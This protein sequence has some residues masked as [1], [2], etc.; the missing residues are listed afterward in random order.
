MLPYHQKD[1]NYPQ[2]LITPSLRRQHQTCP[3]TAPDLGDWQLLTPRLEV[4]LAFQ[5]PGPS[6]TPVRW[7]PSLMLLL[8]SAS[9]KSGCAKHWHMGSHPSIPSGFS[10]QILAPRSQHIH[11]FLHLLR[12]LSMC[13]WK[14]ILVLQPEC[15]CSSKICV[16][17]PLHGNVMTFEGGSFLV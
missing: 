9:Q 2:T 10:A 13:H 7:I 6:Q 4:A 11:P 3:Y 1:T 5:W 8:T 12:S 17:K 16:L 15:L 14:V